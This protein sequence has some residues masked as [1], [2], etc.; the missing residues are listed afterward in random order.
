[1]RDLKRSTSLW[2][3]ESGYFPTFKGWQK[4]Y[5][6]FNIS[7]SHKDAVASYINSQQEHHQKLNFEA[8]YQRLVLKN[9][10]VYYQRKAD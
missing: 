3:K 4:E 1:M 8:E 10:L 2:M 7:F 6:A 9:G 5:A